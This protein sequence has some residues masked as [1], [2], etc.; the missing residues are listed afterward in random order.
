MYYSHGISFY[1]HITDLQVKER[2]RYICANVLRL[3]PLC[4]SDDNISVACFPLGLMLPQTQMKNI[5]EQVVI[6]YMRLLW[7]LS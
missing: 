6:K 3:S 1:N 4:G 7:L 5:W 2:Y